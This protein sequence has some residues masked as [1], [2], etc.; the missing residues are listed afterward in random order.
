V[1]IVPILIDQANQESI[2]LTNI[3]FTEISLKFLAAMQPDKI[4]L[5][6]KAIEL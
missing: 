2:T 6:K 1:A 4:C 5:H 3:N